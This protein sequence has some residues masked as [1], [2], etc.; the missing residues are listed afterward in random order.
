[1]FRLV[2]EESVIGKGV[3][4]SLGEKEKIG[5]DKEEVFKSM[6]SII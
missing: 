3:R 2:G 5:R 4:K 6:G 1:M